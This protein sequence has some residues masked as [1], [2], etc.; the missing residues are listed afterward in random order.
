MHA[1]TTFIN[2]RPFCRSAKAC[3][4]AAKGR[5]HCSTPE[6]SPEYGTTSAEHTVISHVAYARTDDAKPLRNRPVLTL[7]RFDVAPQDSKREKGAAN[8]H[9]K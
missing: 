9:A 1:N 4:D 6:R 5:V 2:T 7:R 3:A 8:G